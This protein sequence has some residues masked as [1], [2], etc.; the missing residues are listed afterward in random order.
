M[1]WDFPRL[2]SVKY[3][4]GGYSMGDINLRIQIFLN[5]IAVITM[6]TT[7]QGPEASPSEQI[8]LLTT[9][10]VTCLFYYHCSH[11]T[12]FHF[13]RLYVYVHAHLKKLNMLS[14]PVF[15]SG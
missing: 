11:S 8:S 4:D 1:L 5:L 2:L 7:L 9:S 13:Q 10:D 14:Q 6:R 15:L 3:K 12:L